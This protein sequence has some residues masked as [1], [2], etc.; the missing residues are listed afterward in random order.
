MQKDIVFID[1]SVYVKE[2]YFSEGNA[3][4]TLYKLAKEGIISIVSTDITN[5]E[6]MRHMRNDCLE[7]FSKLKK[8]CNVLRNISIY[9]D[10]FDRTNKAVV[11]K[12]V[13][14][15]LEKNMKA[16]GV[17]SLGYQL[18]ESDVK[19]VFYSFF[20]E[21]APFSDH[22]KSEFP[23]AFVLTLLENYAY[24][25]RLSIIVLSVDD[26]M[27]KYDSYRLY[28]A[29]YKE[30][31]NEKKVVKEKL[32]SIKSALDEQYDM[33]CS[34]IQSKCEESLD[35]T[36][37]YIYSVEGV[38]ISFVT[39]NYVHVNF[40][41]D[42][43]YIYNEEDG[44]VGVEVECDIE[45][46]VDVEYES[47]SNAYYDS[48]DKKWYGTESDRTNI[49]KSANCYVDLKFD[50]QLGLGIEEFDVDDVLREI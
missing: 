3:I 12:E 36:N 44:A 33:I 31:I 18:D 47:T 25:N 43:F 35:D 2:K 42:S 7:A 23:D 22:K 30:F 45:F 11:E 17:Y 37:L 15:I 14:E 24:K 40:D 48:E 32:D 6:I 19:N 46:S 20:K 26:D 41:K 39:V 29:D 1:T 49:R 50:E 9:K 21:K 13:N 10:S 34:E 5:Q 38:D 8:Q 16:A 4:T 27:Q 28:T